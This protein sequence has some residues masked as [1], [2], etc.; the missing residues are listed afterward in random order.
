MKNVEEKAENE[1]LNY[2]R[3]HKYCFLMKLVPVFLFGKVLIVLNK[4]LK[5]TSWWFEISGKV[6]FV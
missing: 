4:L 3:A 1:V 6:S 2:L 5:Y